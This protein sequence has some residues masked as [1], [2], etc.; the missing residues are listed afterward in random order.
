MEC[1]VCGN[2]KISPFATLCSVC[3]TD[4]VAFPLLEDLEEQSVVMLKDKVSLEGE[5]TALEQIRRRDKVRYRR[6]LS[7]MYW[8]LFLLPL[9]FFVCGKKDLIK[10]DTT[11]VEALQQENQSLQDRIEELENRELI[12]PEGK[13]GEDKEKKEREKREEE[14]EV[15]HII[16][17]GDNFS[18]LAKKY[19]QDESKWSILSA[20]NP[21]VTDY[22]KM[23]PG[24]TILIKI[25]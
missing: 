5:L 6:S 10:V 13:E 3:D 19:L 15:L 21:T 22:G 4:I 7:R 23:M 24:D 20:L 14:G 18:V 12:I 9:M 1:P 8:F 17:Q 11:K 25:R 16:Q 2:K